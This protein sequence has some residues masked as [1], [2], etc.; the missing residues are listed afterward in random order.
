MNIGTHQ[1]GLWFYPHP[2]PRGLSS[3][4]S[5]HLGRAVLG[6]TLLAYSFSPPERLGSCHKVNLQAAGF[7]LGNT[8]L[9]KADPDALFSSFPSNKS[10]DW[11]FTILSNFPL[12]RVLYNP[13]RFPTLMN[14]TN[15]QICWL[16]VLFNYTIP[17]YGVQT[18][19]T[20]HCTS[21]LLMLLGVY[22]IVT[23]ASDP[24]KE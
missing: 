18:S 15:Q 6:R 2:T 10:T 21:L 19:P 11:F 23:E 1:T 8:L 7:L 17:H 3:F 12:T 24:S 5:R 22:E 9:W 20:L 13:S 4:I 16:I 14:R